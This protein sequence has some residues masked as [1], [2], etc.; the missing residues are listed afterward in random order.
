[1]SPD[2]QRQICTWKGGLHNVPSEK[3]KLKQQWGIITCWLEW[4]ESGTLSAPNADEDMEQQELSYIAG[5]S[6]K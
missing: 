3:C 1:M 4:P 6:A 2:T 5:G